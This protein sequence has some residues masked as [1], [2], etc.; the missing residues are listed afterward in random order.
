MA[1]IYLG[2]R[3]HQSSWDYLRVS[4][5]NGQ[6]T[7]NQRRELEAVDR[8]PG[9]NVVEIFEDKRISGAKGRDKRAAFDRLLKAV[10]ARKIDMVAASSIDRL[11][12]SMQHLAGFLG[13]LQAVGCDLYLHQQALDTTDPRTHQRWAG[14]ALRKRASRWVVATR[15]TTN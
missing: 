6:T 11:G 2:G 7:E 4:T 9:W 1:P 14:K 12:C 5:T 10:T 3:G 13:E 15:R 8:R